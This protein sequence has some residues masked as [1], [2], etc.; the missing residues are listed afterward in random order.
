MQI[1]VATIQRL[2]FTVVL[3]AL[4]AMPS[5]LARATDAL[6]FPHFRHV[7][8][9]LVEMPTELPQTLTL[10]TDEDFAPFSFKTA[11]DKLA[12]ISVQLGLAACEELK[13]KCSVK[14]KPFSALLG[15]LR[16]KEGDI[17][18]G[19]PQASSKL[20]EEFLATRPYYYSYSQFALRNGTNFP[21]VD[22]KS[23]AGRRL[24][25]V[26]G[27]AQENFVRKYYDRSNLIPFAAE[28]TLFETLRTGGLDVVFADSSHIAFWMKGNAARGCCVPFGA[29]FADKASFTHGLS[30]L[31]RGTDS[32][33]RDAFD[34][35]LDRLQEKG[36]TSKILATYL[37]SS[38]F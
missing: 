6:Q 1:M 32:A 20:L 10:L 12:G 5:K 30:I 8:K 23:L 37:P 16:Q 24:G 9:A 36:I 33:L 13:V 34:T 18:L 2:Y 27:S 26:K 3:L 35:A 38:P 31:T 21:G 28:D 4:V 25:F 15:A 29:A 19:G 22:S 7:D 17:V 14:S 11:D